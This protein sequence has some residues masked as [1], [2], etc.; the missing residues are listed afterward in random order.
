[1]IAPTKIYDAFPTITPDEAA[2]IICEGL[3]S[4]PKELNT[5]IGTAG[6][7]LH[8]L[9]PKAMDQILHMAYRVFPESSSA[10]KGSGKSADSDQSSG[11]GDNGSGDN[12]QD[13]K[14]SNEAFA[15]A[16]LLKGV[17]W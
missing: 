10:K 3:R 6:E 1:M 17:H 16:H 13:G 9:M 4:R 12:G 11:D 5:R 8:A 14:A 15:L 7:V 2:D